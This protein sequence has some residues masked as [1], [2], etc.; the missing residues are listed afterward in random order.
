MVYFALA[1]CLTLGNK[2]ALMQVL[3]RSYVCG[4]FLVGGIPVCCRSCAEILV[5]TLHPVLLVYSAMNERHST[6]MIHY[7]CVMTHYHFISHHPNVC[8]E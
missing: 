5:A 8:G 1:V 4:L 2:R 3:S 6:S 7:H